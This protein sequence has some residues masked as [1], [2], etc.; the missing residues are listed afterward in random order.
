MRDVAAAMSHGIGAGGE[1]MSITLEEA[2]QRWGP[3]GLGFLGGPIV[4]S[5]RA[6]AKLGWRPAG[7][8]LP[9]ELIHGSLRLSPPD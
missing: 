6:T 9:Y 8:S 3:L 4:S 1:T 5:V 2:Q 7:P